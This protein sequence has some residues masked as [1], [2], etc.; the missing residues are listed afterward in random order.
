LTTFVDTNV[1]I[2]IVG[3]DPVWLGWSAFALEAAQKQG[4]VRIGPI[5][6]AEGATRFVARTDWEEVLNRLAI[7]LES[8]LTKPALFAA[9]QAHARYRADGGARS[10]ILPDFLIG[11]QAAFRGACLL[12]RDPARFRTY[13]PQLEVISPP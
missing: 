8:D 10:Q 3:A 11:A 2:D 4:D 6:Y 5:V 12:T 9:A 7:S 13:F 1:L